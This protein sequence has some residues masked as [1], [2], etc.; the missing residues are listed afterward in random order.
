MI[1]RAYPERPQAVYFY[2]TCLVDLFYPQAGLA[3][4]QLLEREGVRVLFPQDQTCC[5]QPAY[6]SG[7][8]EEAYA[9]A[10]RQLALFP[11]DLPVV[12]PSASCAGMM[13]N[14]YPDL[15]RGRPEEREARALAGR[16]Y[17]L[18]E[19]LVHV[20][21]V[22]LKDLGEPVSVTVHTS[23]SAWR[24]MGV[25]QES[26]TLLGQLANVELREL[27][28]ERECCGFG[29]TFAVKHAAISAAIVADKAAAVRSSG[30]AQLVSADCGCLMNIGGVLEREGS[31]PAVD[32]I[33][34]FLWERTRE[35]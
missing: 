35:R 6:N 32:H 29:G 21:D 28:R 16:V 13:R 15:F 26:K 7:Y 18:T 23:C 12:V 25:A 19:F 17:E 20:L 4:V 10:A 31:G 5:G 27:E 14:H 22:R 34:S 9:V 24:E 30:A 3:G 11:E 1:A 8:H 2:A 33:A